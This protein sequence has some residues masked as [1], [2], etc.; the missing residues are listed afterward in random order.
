VSRRYR[1]AHKPRVTAS[2]A[3]ANI[4]LYCLMH[5]F[6]KAGGELVNKST[7]G[8]AAFPDYS[9]GRPQGA[10]FAVAKIVRD[11]EREG[12]L[13]YYSNYHDVFERRGYYAVVKE[14]RDDEYD[15]TGAMAA[16]W[17]GTEGAEA[18]IGRVFDG[19]ARG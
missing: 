18:A 14:E 6:T 11:M 9:W 4:L 17:F 19:R 15:S 16:A 8:S 10:A 1:N 2:E 3:A 7:L 13:R 5:D 12:L